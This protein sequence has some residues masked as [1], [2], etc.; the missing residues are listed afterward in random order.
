MSHTLTERQIVLTL[1]ALSAVTPLAIDMYLPAFP[2]IATELHTSI[3]NVEF[4][5]SLYFFGMAMGQLFGGPISDAYGRRPMVII[6]LIVFGLSS[7]LLSITPQIETFWILRALQS[8]GGGIATVNVSATVRDMFDGK[9][10]ARIFSLIGMV[11]LMAPLLAPSLG[12]LVL[13][14]FEWEIIF[15]LL[16]LYTLFALGYYLFR[17]PS[18]K[19]KRSKITPIQNYKTVLSHKLAMI[20][21]ISQI[22]CSSGMY[23]FITSSSF[24]YMEHFQVSPSNF[25][26]FFGANVLMIMIL[27]RL[28]AWLVKR[29]EPLS[30]LRFGM[31]AQAILGIL[32]F[33]F[34]NENLYLLF[35]LIGLYV[36]TLGFIFSNSISLTLEFFPTISASA[37][38]IIGVLQYSVGALMGFIASSLH[39]GTLLT[40][41]GVMMVVSLCGT[42]L[43]LLGS[44]GYI[45]HHGRQS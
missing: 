36:G 6:G 16:A 38:A 8:F 20:F 42:T 39:D 35:P 2:A 41:T 30:L 18:V 11:M 14:F 32:L 34:R 23:T 37:N 5:L 9:E 29:K 26:L 10:S 43:L 1:A 44:R 25:A 17:F 33:V 28:N 40:I 21:I 45:P 12:S 27:G 13:H 3:P 31:C 19:Q 15:I 24:I 4:S 7:L 22:L